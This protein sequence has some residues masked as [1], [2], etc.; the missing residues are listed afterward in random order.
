MMDIYNS[1]T[2]ESS[3]GEMRDSLAVSELMDNHFRIT[4]LDIDAIK[5]SD[6]IMSFANRG[7]QEDL[8]WTMLFWCVVLKIIYTVLAT[9]KRTR[10]A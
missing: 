7:N 3:G 2:M 1:L 4:Q 9:C 8:G 6:I 10:S 5:E